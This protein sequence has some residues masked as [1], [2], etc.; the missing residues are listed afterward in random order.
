MPEVK[1]REPFKAALDYSRD[2]ILQS[3]VKGETMKLTR[4]VIELVLLRVDLTERCDGHET[5]SRKGHNQ[6][7]NT[8]AVND[9]RVVLFCVGFC[10]VPW[11]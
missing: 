10:V 6:S 2:E 8:L 7:S 11:Q 4:L 3:I 5:S 1:Q 9:L